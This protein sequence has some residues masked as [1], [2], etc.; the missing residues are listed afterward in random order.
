L[1]NFVQK[2]AVILVLFIES[3]DSLPAV[4]LMFDFVKTKFHFVFKNPESHLI[5]P[6]SWTV[7]FFWGFFLLTMALRLVSVVDKST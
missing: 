1:S 3:H 7:G 5:L 6:L 2:T 4:V